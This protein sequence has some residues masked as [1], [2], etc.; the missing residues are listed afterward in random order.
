M[1]QIALV[2]RLTRDPELKFVGANGTALCQFSI[3]VNEKQGDKEVTKFFDCKCWKGTAEGVQQ[4]LQKGA[5]VVV[6]GKLDQ[7]TW[8]D[9]QSGQKR[10]KVVVVATAVGSAIFKRAESEPA[11]RQAEAPKSSPVQKPAPDDDGVPF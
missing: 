10:S 11:P 3:A 9:K 8:D 2:G 4:S 5:A 6:V 1:N 7:E